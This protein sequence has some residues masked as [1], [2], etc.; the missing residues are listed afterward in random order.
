MKQVNSEIL[1]IKPNDVVILTFGKE[2]DLE[3]AEQVA[4]RVAE[5]FPN[6]K[7]IMNLEGLITDIKIIKEDIPFVTGLT[8]ADY[9]PPSS[10]T[11]SSWSPE[12]G[13][14]ELKVNDYIY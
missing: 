1:Y 12:E 4:R 13:Y 5:V 6:N 8:T 11:T 7:F 9:T 3:E 2:Y 14:K 10:W